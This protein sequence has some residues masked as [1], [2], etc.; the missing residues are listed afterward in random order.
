M[1]RKKVRADFLRTSRLSVNLMNNDLIVQCMNVNRMMSSSSVN[2]EYIVMYTCPETDI[3]TTYTM[4]KF[5]KEKVLH[6]AC[7]V[8]KNNVMIPEEWFAKYFG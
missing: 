3:V 4:G 5:L 7:E 6:D 1:T 8:I 2:F